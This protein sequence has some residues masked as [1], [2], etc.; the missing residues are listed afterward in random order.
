[1]TD[2]PLLVWSAAL[3]VPLAVG[4][5][6]E[7]AALE[8]AALEDAAL[9]DAA[10]EG[11][12]VDGGAAAGVLLVPQALIPATAPVSAVAITMVR[13]DFTRSLLRGKGQ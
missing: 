5:A 10:L 7:D 3:S 1:M 9:E 13:K 2:L 8:D 11:G 6:L 12:A 4:A